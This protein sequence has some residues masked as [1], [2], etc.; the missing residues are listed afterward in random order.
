MNNRVFI[1]ENS[2][3]PHETSVVSA[4][5]I[6]KELNYEVR[7]VL[8]KLAYDRLKSY[9]TAENIK[10][11]RSFHLGDLLRCI[12]DIS[13]KDFLYFNTIGLRVAAF[14]LFFSSLT[15]HN[16]FYIRNANSWF[17]LQPNAE[18]ATTKFLAWCLY[19]SKRILL[20]RAELLVVGHNNI[21]TYLKQYTQLPIWYV[22]FNIKKP[23]E[24]KDSA[25]TQRLKVVVPGTVDFERK[26]NTLIMD[27]IQLIDKSFLGQFEVVFLGRAANKY[28][29]DFLE[30]WS[31]SLKNSIVF[32]PGFIEQAEFDRQLSEADIIMGVINVVHKSKY[33][34]E[35][36]GKTKDTGIEAHAIAYSKPLVVNADYSADPQLKTSVV[37]FSSAEE[38]RAILERALTEKT[39]LE[40]IK[41]NAIKNCRNFELPVLVK[42]IKEVYPL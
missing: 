6:F 36:Y 41:G 29:K 21:R 11:Y 42:D 20:R 27:A 15:P 23:L 34:T 16:I 19:I 25:P 38:L 4:I 40:E 35:E 7:V 14:I 12:S 5:T 17:F 10:A 26:N 37:A 30:S 9:L 3:S 8:G 22:P 1:V 32:Y 39:W 13:R 31:A 24:V 18:K 33:Y 2:D 28:S